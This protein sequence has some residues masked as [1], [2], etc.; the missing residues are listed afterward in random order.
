[1]RHQLAALLALLTIGIAL[2]LFSLSGPILL[3]VTPLVLYLIGAQFHRAAPPQLSVIRSLSTTRVVPGERVTVEL[4]ITNLGAEIPELIVRD[5]LPSGLVR[6]DGES[7]A[8]LMLPRNATA[9]IR[10]Q[11]E[12]TRGS[13]PFSHVV[14]E[15]AGDFPLLARSYDLKCPRE[16]ITLPHHRSLSRIP[17]AP[18]RTLVYA[19]TNPAR[20]GGEGTEFFDVR[21]TSNSAR[22]K[23]IN[24]RAT[25][26]AN[27]RIYINEFQQERVAD[28]AIML[29]CREA[30]Y[31]AD[32]TGSLFDAATSAA[33]SLADTVLEAGNRVGYLGYG[34]MIDWIAP[35]FGRSQKHRILTR[36][37]RSVTGMSHVFTELDN[38]PPRLFPQG[39][40]VVIISP[41]TEGDARSIRSIL[42]HGHAILIVSPDPTPYEL[43]DATDESERASNLLIK[44]ERRVRLQQLR[45]AGAAVIDWNTG[46]PLEEAV[47]KSL[48]MVNAI[49][50]RR[51]R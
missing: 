2:G 29:D 12:A 3:V 18:R 36:I 28:V 10:Y 17:I 19:G 51:R 25:A 38:V 6:V 9:T 42:S 49:W 31:R 34:L 7:E 23:H 50:R 27:D 5:V 48:G 46:R 45:H 8:Q 37:A 21:E 43:A 4:T 30:A 1:M 35:G 26:R 32:E 41:L 33:A 39:S 47:G 40:Q 22:L 11:V 24:W 16:L 14:T 44:L 20:T 13:Y 15:V